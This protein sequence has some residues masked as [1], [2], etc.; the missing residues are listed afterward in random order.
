MSICS[1]LSSSLPNCSSLIPVSTTSLRTAQSLIFSIAC[2][3]LCHLLNHQAVHCAGVV[4]EDFCEHRPRWLS[5][6]D[7]SPVWARWREMSPA[8]WLFSKSVRFF[9]KTSSFGHAFLHGGPTLATLTLKSSFPRVSRR[10]QSLHIIVAVDHLIGISY[11]VVPATFTFCKGFVAVHEAG[12]KSHRSE[13]D[14]DLSCWHREGSTQGHF[15]WLQPMPQ[16][17]DPS[18]TPPVV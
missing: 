11:T 13:D 5:D 2:S 18:A 16:R 14:C 3:C 6:G 15:A 7:F 12:C 17:Q 4:L 1:S 10:H 8:S 9:S